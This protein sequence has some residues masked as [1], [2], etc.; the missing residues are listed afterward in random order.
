MEFSEQVVAFAATVATGAFLGILFD[1]YRVLNRSLR[2]HPVF[3]SVTDL[4]FWVVATVIIF[5]SL[6]ASNWGELRM[7][8]F[9]GLAGGALLY[10][11]MMSRFVTKGFCLIFSLIRFISRWIRI[12]IVTIVI[13]PVGVCTRLLYSPFGFARRKSAVWFKKR[14]GKPPDEITPP[15]Q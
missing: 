12:I 8:V 7:Y 15:R 10:F 13:K 2:V 9:I 1:F 5:A 11:R 4:L 6:L 14:T 3:T